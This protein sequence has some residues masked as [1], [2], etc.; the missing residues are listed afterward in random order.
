MDHNN[1]DSADRERLLDEV[2]LAYLK[3]VE[4]GER[5]DRQEWLRGYPELAGERSILLSD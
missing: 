4:A 2:L 3:A 1:P 5:P